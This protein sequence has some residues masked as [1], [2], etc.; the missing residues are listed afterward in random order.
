MNKNLI[1][2]ALVLLFALISFV[3]KFFVAAPSSK[4]EFAT[5]KIGGHEFKIE[6]AKDNLSRMRGLSNRES[7]ERDQG[8]LFIFD[9]AARHGFWMKGMKIPLDILWIKDNRIIGITQNIPISKD[10]L[11]PAYYP[12]H[13][14]D[15]VLE[16]NAGT[17]EKYN[18][19]VGDLIEVSLGL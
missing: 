18:L 2:L 10:L 13:P 1:I 8:M 5:L 7:L 6:V 4:G 11:P 9:E 12:P 19:K 3:Y 17:A 16:L 14:V 15:R